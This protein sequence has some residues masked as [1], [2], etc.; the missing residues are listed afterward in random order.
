LPL[1]PAKFDCNILRFYVTTFIQ[2]CVEA[3]YEVSIDF[4]RSTAQEPNHRIVGCCARAQSG[5]AA[6]PPNS[7]MNSRRVLSCMWLPTIR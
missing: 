3:A 6:A 2:A 1:R 5:H 7:V 4:R